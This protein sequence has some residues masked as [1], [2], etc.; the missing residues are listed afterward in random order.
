VGHREKLAWPIPLAATLF[1]GASQVS[2]FNTVQTYYI[3]A[4]TA[5]AAS[6]LAAGA[7]LR[8]VIGGVVP[9][10][11]GGMFDKIGY[12]MGMSVFGIISLILMPAPLLFYW[13]GRR[14]RERFPFKG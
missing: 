5:N 1:F 3:D 2:I 4:Y 14:L 13:T 7:F 8:S 12:G 6:A 10:F 11:V 9:I